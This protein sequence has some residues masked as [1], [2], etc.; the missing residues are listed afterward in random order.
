MKDETIGAIAIAALVAAYS[1]AAFLRHA[2]RPSLGETVS[3]A[4]SKEAGDILQAEVVAL[5]PEADEAI[6]LWPRGGSRSE[7]LPSRAALSIWLCSAS[8]PRDTAVVLLRGLPLGRGKIE[9]ASRA[10][11][12]S[13]E[14]LRAPPLRLDCASRARFFILEMKASEVREP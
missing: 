2:N 9:S 7:A 8:A 1:A 10:G 12:L 3:E 11:K 13:I 5:V 4:L 14:E 6:E